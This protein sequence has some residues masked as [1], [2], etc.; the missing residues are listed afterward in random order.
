VRAR[1]HDSRPR[2]ATQQKIERVCEHGLAGSGLAGDHV[3][4]WAQPQLGL[5]DQQKV[6]DA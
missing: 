6:L 5:L 3:Q 2:A 1:S 4:A